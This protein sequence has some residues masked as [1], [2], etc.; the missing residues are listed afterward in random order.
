[1][2][3]NSQ[4]TLYNVDLHLHQLLGKQYEPTENT[5]LNEKF[6]ILPNEKLPA[7]VYPTLKYYAIGVGGTLNIDNVNKY[8]YSEH[9]AIDAALFEHIPFIM[10]NVNETDLT[11]E[12]RAN[13]RL[14]VIKNFNGINYACYYLK[15]IPSYEL[16][17]TFHMIR[18][19]ENGVAV[20][21]PTLSVL[22]M[23]NSQI[24]SPEPTN[25]DLTFENQNN[26]GF[27]TKVAK[28]TFSLTPL[29][30]EEISNCLKIMNLN[31][32]GLTEIG[33]VTG[34]DIETG[35]VKEAICTQIAMHLGINFNLATEMAKGSTII[36]ILE[37]GGGE[38]I[39]N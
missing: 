34:H 15:V 2:V 13:Y 12:E 21:S 32:S 11:T 35:G 4:R 39:V 26:L 10:R 8:S 7:G 37:I 19:V 17:P 31:N 3:R 33:I 36:K 23:T 27:V 24:L 18:T 5:T 9:L 25:R 16:K 14:R 20:S 38:P 30:L 1:M 28:L 6:Q 29:E 22:N